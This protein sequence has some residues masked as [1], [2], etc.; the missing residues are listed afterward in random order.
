MFGKD[1]I[2]DVPNA[3][4]MEQKKVRRSLYL[5]QVLQLIDPSLSNLVVQRG[6]GISN[7]PEP[8]NLDPSL[9]LEYKSAFTLT[10]SVDLSKEEWV[11][12]YRIVLVSLIF[13]AA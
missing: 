4:F 11:Y 2:Y 12:I 10:E 8:L 7:Y 3:K 6:Y 9:D 13:E 1:V 5:T